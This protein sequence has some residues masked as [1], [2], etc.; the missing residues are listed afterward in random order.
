MA[1]KYYLHPDNPEGPYRIIF[2]PPGSEF[3]NL[4]LDSRKIKRI[5]VAP[6][7]SFISSSIY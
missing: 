4:I 1:L 3:N 5:V 6:D 2:N 7:P